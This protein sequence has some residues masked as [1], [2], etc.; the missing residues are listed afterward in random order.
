MAS[1]VDIC[2]TGLA[3]LGDRATLASIDP[4]EGSAQADHCAQF[5]PI[6][7]D[8]ALASHN[9]RFCF[10]VSSLAALDASLNSHPH[11]LFAYALPTDF[12]VARELVLE[13]GSI[14]A[15]TPDQ[16]QWEIAQTD[17]GTPVL[18]TNYEDVALG[19]TKRVSNPQRYPAKLVSALG[20]LMASYLAGPVIKG[21]SGMQTSVAMRQYWDKLSMEAAVTDANQGHTKAVYTPASVRARGAS[22]VSRREL[23]FWAV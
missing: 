13:N 14:L 20:Y 16:P 4:P 15:Y 10:T 9:W 8:E 6:A 2:N 19:F 5:W 17:A 23:P 1:V 21:K 11:W 22:N 3:L 18:F 7:R 12:L